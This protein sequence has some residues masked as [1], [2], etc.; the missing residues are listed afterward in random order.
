MKNRLSIHLKAQEPATTS[1]KIQTGN[2]KFL[3]LSGIV[4]S[5][6][7]DP[8]KGAV[9]LIP[10]IGKS[11]ESDGT[12]AFE[13]LAIPPGK[14]HL[15]VFADGYMDFISDVFGLEGS[16]KT[17]KITLLKKLSEEI[18]VTATRTKKLYAEVPVR[19]DGQGYRANAGLPTGGSSCA[20]HWRQSRVQLSELQFHPGPY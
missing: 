17:F 13:F 11:S 10:E 19:T 18:V 1:S 14:Y 20:H 12:G 8:I 4:K 15:E 6:E 16:K 5:Y 2:V 9:I 3:K 7:G